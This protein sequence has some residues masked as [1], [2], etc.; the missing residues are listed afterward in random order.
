VINIMSILCHK[1]VILSTLE[2]WPRKVS[3]LLLIAVTVTKWIV[4]LPVFGFAFLLAS[5]T[6]DQADH[7]LCRDSIGLRYAYLLI[8]STPITSRMPP[9]TREHLRP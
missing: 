8:G 1:V 3:Y 5:R 2:Y 7:Y 9:I 6:A 4:R